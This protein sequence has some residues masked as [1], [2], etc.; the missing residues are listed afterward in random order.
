MLLLEDEEEAW[1]SSSEDEAE[2]HAQR[3][4][5]DPEVWQDYHSEY[6]VSMYHQLRDYVASTGV[7]ILDR[8][9]FHD[10][11]TF[12]HAKSSGRKPPC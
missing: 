2:Q 9:T 11:A 12:C 6:L 4:E 3:Y 1:F 8:C 7:P 10:F 5:E